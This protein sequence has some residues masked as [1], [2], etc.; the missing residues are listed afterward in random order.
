MRSVLLRAN[1]Q[2]LAEGA[3]VMERVDAA[4]FAGGG[5]ASG[6]VGAHLRH[7]LD[8]YDA[9]LAGMTTGRI[10][11]DA[12]ARDA[13]TETD[14]TFALSR[15]ARTA[16]ALLALEPGALPA[17]LAVRVGG[18]LDAEPRWAESSPERELEALLSH[19]L[20]HWAL[21]AAALRPAGLEIPPEFGVAPST[22]RARKE[23]AVRA[24]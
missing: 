18:E 24:G 1:V 16:D 20:H 6:A 5:A 12:R 9:F 11:Y 13:R 4:V 22:L 3:R 7:C 23:P 21:I 14:R 8:F 19:T 10:D 2:L 17:A 15:L